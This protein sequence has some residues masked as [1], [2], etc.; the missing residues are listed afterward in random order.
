MTAHPESAAGAPTDADLVRE[1]LEA[2]GLS[3]RDAARQLRIDDRSMRYYCAGKLPVP[4]VVF[5]PPG[6]GYVPAAMPPS[7]G[8]FEA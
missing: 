7:V 5:G 1:H 2:L 6:V 8:M 3:Q 4:P